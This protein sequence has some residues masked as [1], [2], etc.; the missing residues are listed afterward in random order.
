MLIPTSDL[1]TGNERIVP[2]KKP[3]ILYIDHA[4]NIPGIESL[5][6]IRQLDA[7]LHGIADIDK[8][9]YGSD[10][11]R[12]APDYDELNSL[13]YASSYDAVI[14]RAHHGKQDNAHNVRSPNGI[15]RV[16]NEIKEHFK[17]RKDEKK[18][19]EEGGIDEYASP[20]PYIVLVTEKDLEKYFDDMPYSEVLRPNDW[21]LL[22]K[23]VRSGAEPTGEESVLEKII[24][25]G[26]NK[27]LESGTR[28]PVAF[29][30]LPRNYQYMIENGWVVVSDDVTIGGKVEK[31]FFY[32]KDGERIPY[33]K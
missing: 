22:L 29:A 11:K 24:S 30:I 33:P 25:E 13:L 9:Y 5:E 12:H 16:I 32:E 1:Y 23:R 8:F 6:Q 27:E 14:V 10:G 28:N 4:M 3:R 20:L 31:Q 26:A 17:Q 19:F 7:P 18:P 15:M 21:N 2:D